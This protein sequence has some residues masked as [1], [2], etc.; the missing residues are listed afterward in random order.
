[1]A[2]ERPEGAVA[3]IATPHG[4][5]GYRQLGKALRKMYEDADLVV[6]PDDSEGYWVCHP[7]DPRATT[8]ETC[9][10]GC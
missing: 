2:T 10:G 5:D 8:D 4:L 3:W 6:E 9:P 7:R 1:M